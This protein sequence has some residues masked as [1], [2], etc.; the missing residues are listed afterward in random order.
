MQ[1]RHGSAGIPCVHVEDVFDVDHAVSQRGAKTIFNEAPIRIID[2]ISGLPA[3][4]STRKIAL[5]KSCSAI[6]AK[7][8]QDAT[9][10]VL[11]G[12]RLLA[13]GSSSLLC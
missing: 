2:S 4:H 9:L 5:N 1:R 10:R 6:P 13:V 12:R 8:L 3:L 7:D 11:I